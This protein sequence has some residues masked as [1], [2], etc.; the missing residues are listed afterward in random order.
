MTKMANVAS[1]I[2]GFKA[3]KIRT[4]VKITVNLLKKREREGQGRKKKKK[5]DQSNRNDQCHKRSPTKYPKGSIFTFYFN[6][7]YVSWKWHE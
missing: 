3:L 5:S 2:K 6:N 7:R 4:L 1:N